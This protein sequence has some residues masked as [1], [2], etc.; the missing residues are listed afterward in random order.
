LWRLKD[1]EA[2]SADNMVAREHHEVLRMGGAYMAFDGIKEA[3]L[4]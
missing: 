1:G 3:H 4:I 2:L